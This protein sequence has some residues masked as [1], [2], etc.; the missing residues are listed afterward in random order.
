MEIEEPLIMEELMDR[1]SH[2]VADTEYRTK[3][4]RTRTQM[5]DLTQELHGVALLLQGI[6]SGIS[7]TVDLDLGCLNLH[8]LAFAVKMPFTLKLAPV[9]I[10]F[11]N[12]SPSFS[13]STTI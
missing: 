6:D 9:V 11:K 10:G 3:R 13:T 12:S 8:T 5:G 1:I 4:V 2:V 7:R